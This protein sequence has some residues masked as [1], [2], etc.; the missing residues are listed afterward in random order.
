MCLNSSYYYS[1][2]LVFSYGLQGWS[3]KWLA[4]HN[5]NF[6]M[7]QKQPG[8]VIGRYVGKTMVNT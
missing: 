7:C 4:K 3:R 5:P 2:E 8:I 6:M 1:K